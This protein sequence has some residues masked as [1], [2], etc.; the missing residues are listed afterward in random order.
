[1]PSKKKSA[2]GILRP[3][4]PITEKHDLSAFDCGEPALDDWLRRRALRNEI[5]G[6]SRSYVVCNDPG[7]RVVAYYSLAAGAAA[8]AAAPG[9]VRRNMPDPIPVMILGRLA[10]DRAFQ[11]CGLGR[12]M[13][14]D[15]ILRTIQAASIAGIRA[16]LVHALSDDARQFYQRCGFRPSPIDPMTLMLTVAEAE[17]ALARET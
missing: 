11:G 2:A 7:Q 5:S 13:L 12:G 8:H 4:E 10:V 1:V 6:G 15:A 14:R 3:P 9:R 16:I 17:S